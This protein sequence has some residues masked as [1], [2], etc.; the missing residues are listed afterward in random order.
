MVFDGYRIL[1]ELHD[2]SR[3]HIY[4]AVDN[5]DEQLVAL[6]IPS[7]DLRDDSAYRK[8]FMM[9]EWTARRI[10][11]PHVLKPRT[12]ARKRNYLYVVM[13]F[14]EGQ[15]L[16]QWMLDNPKPDLETVRGIVEQIAAG[17]RAFHR[18]EMLHQDLRPE[19]IM[20]DKTGTVKIIDFGSVKV[21]GIVESEPEA[22]H[23]Q[24]LGTVQYTAPEHFLSE[25][26]TARSDLFSLAVITYQMLSGKLPYGAQAAR[27][28]TKS[29]FRKLKYRPLASTERHIPA[30]IDGV[31]QKAL[32]PD[33]YKR[34]E[35]LSEF[36]FDL[37]NP[38]PKYLGSRLPL[39][40]RNPL[41][42]WKSAS[43]ALALI[44]LLLLLMRFG[45]R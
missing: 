3:S 15:T 21:A 38:D 45:I 16:T 26:A 40:E 22:D 23:E 29:Q 10:N 4:L 17:L 33:P 28:R 37:R 42:F 18:M 8:R 9:E 6:K 34:H 36:L 19:N 5:E 7:L 41:L 35:A 11:S 20:I 43:F 2:S 31:L 14:V 12:Q 25:P 13:E 32:D 27:A 24:I 30:W 39:I 44:V 1:R